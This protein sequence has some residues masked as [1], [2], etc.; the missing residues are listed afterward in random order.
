MRGLVYSESGYRQVAGCFKHGLENV[1]P[2]KYG[3]LLN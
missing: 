3:E 2:I 1:D